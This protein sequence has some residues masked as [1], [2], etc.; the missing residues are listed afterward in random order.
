MI[1]KIT[2]GLTFLTVM[3][4][5]EVYAQGYV[6]DALTFGQIRSTGSA[7][8]MGL[9]GAQN[10]LGGDISN[11]HHNPAGLGFFKRSEF[12][13]TAAFGDWTN[14]ATLENQFSRLQT[15][16]F[17]LPNL[18]VVISSPKNTLTKEKWKGGSF[19]ISVNR[20]ANLNNQFGYSAVTPTSIADFFADNAFGISEN[21][22]SNG[23]GTESLAFNT[24]V[25]ISAG[26]DGNGRPIYEAF[27]VEDEPAL[28]EDVF[29][30][31]S[32]S[33]V[34]FSY[35]GNYDHKIFFGAGI[36]ITSINYFQRKFL[37]EDYATGDLIGFDLNEFLN[38]SGT[39]INLNFG[40]IYKPVDQVNLGFRFQSPTW[41]R[42]NE[43]YEADM[44]SEFINPS[45]TFTDQTPIVIGRYNMNLPLKLGVGGTFFLGKNGFIT[46]DVDF[47]D[48]S[49]SRFSS[50][51]FN[52]GNI[53]Q[54]IRLL[55]GSTLDYRVGGEFRHNIFRARA[56]YAYY[57]DPFQSS[58]FSDVDR[59]TQQISGGVGVK[60]KKMYFDFTLTDVRFTQ[61]Y[62][63][64]SAFNNAGQE[65][66]PLVTLDNRL[67]TGLL[68]LGFNF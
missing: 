3:G 36:G 17:A 8:I 20:L 53:N 40:L 19:G 31:G 51:D 32:V 37:A 23:A 11:I 60:L 13:F 42:M 4:A 50:T 46:A 28:V 65:I 1:K 34:S 33:Q 45:E 27:N 16:N 52:A 64:Y 48:Y 24:N 58:T 54:E 59:S 41:Y 25:I 68:T 18:G 35:G 56:G 63:P 29:T 7:R 22:L 39:G 26:T 55:Y 67:F 12:S 9:G 61:L 43:Q 57:G 2:Y 66:G 21:A 49:T 5:C 47:V 15:S 44:V 10:S 62:R 14:D 38:L 30:E 6:Q